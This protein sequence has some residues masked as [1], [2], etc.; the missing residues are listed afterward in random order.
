[1]AV[2]L[3][4][5][6]SNAAAR[7]PANILRSG[8]AEIQSDITDE[9]LV[10]AGMD[11]SD[12]RL[13]RQ[14]GPRSYISVPL[15]VQGATV[16]VLTFL[17]ARSGR[18][19]G[20]QDLAVANDLASRAS[21]AIENSQL[22]ARLKDADR[23]KDEFLATLAHELRN[24]LA[25]IHNGLQL[26]R[27]AGRD[28][29]TVEQALTMMERQ[30]GQLVRLVD[31]LLDVS[32]INQGKLELRKERI[33]LAAVL[34]SAV[35]TSRPL[36]VRMGHDLE[37]VLPGQPVVVEADLTR[38]AQVFSNLLN[39]AAKYSERGGRITLTARR[40]GDDAVVSVR[41]TGIGIAADQLPRLFEMFSQVKSALERSQGGLG[42]GLSLVRRLVEMHGG[43]IV[44]RS[45]GPG[46][47]SEFVVRLPVSQSSCRPQPPMDEY[48]G[49]TKIGLRILVVDD[50]RDSAN[51]LAKMLRLMGGD[52]RTAY[53]GEEAVAAAAEFRPDAVVLDIGLPKLNGYEAC[54]RIR[55]LP[56][57]KRVLLIAQ[58]GWGQVEDR[59]RT[60][61]AGFDHHLIKPVDHAVLM[62][63]LAES[64][65]AAKS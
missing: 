42:I 60:Q 25:P 48:R 11:E 33:D 12:L 45:D 49:E 27:M 3:G 43:Q 34:S 29:A 38:L 41:D 52:T 61:Q 39:N 44:A 30:L 5:R 47:G 50:N 63:L 35:E 21:I 19:Y 58:T 16:G 56:G 6:F 2:A 65:P 51:S 36:I 9:M 64:S 55:A 1:L 26:M 24:P 22:Y 31:D 57:A 8:V 13:L 14:L 7:G 18:R 23:R 40:Q 53:D 10:V 15:K 37:V 20:E 54:R 17:W 28:T 62:K 59:Q 32:R 46:K 4:R